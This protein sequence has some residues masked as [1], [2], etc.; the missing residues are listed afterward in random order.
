M[1]LSL[2]FFC[3]HVVVAQD[4]IPEL[5]WQ[6]CFGG[7]G[8]EFLSDFSQPTY[9]YG[10]TKTLIADTDGGFV[11]GG[12]TGPNSNFV[13]PLYG[14]IDIVIFK[15]DREK[16]IVWK[17][18]IGGSK[19]DILFSVQADHDGGY[20][21][22]TTTESTDGDGTGNHS[23][24]SD[25]LIVKLDRNGKVVWKKCFGGT[26]HEVG[27]Q[28]AVVDDGYVFSASTFSYNGDII[29]RNDEGMRSDVWLVKL[30]F[31]GNIIW[32]KTIGGS[33]DDYEGTIK[34]TSDGGFITLNYTTSTDGDAVV[35]P[36]STAK[37]IDLW[38]VKLDANGQIQW[39]NRWN[40]GGNFDFPQDIEETPD[41]E[42]I[43]VAQAD[44]NA[45]NSQSG[46]GVI[47]KMDRNG[48]YKWHK[49]HA[50]A[51]YSSFTDVVI[52]PD[53]TYTVTGFTL[54]GP[55]TTNEYDV[56]LLNFDQ[57]GDLNWDKKFGGSNSDMGSSIVR[58][59][60]GTYYILGVTSSNNG[61]VTGNNGGSDFWLLQVGDYN[62]ITGHAFYDLNTNGI[63]DAN[64]VYIDDVRITAEKNSSINAAIPSNGLYSIYVDTGSF[65]VKATPFNDYFTVV[66][67]S[68]AAAFTSYGN[69]ATI[70]FALR[71]KP[72]R[73]DLVVYISL[74]TPARS[75][76]TAKYKIDYKN[77]GT[78]II[79]AGTVTM[80]S[81]RR[82][83]YLSSLP[84]HTSHLGDTTTWN[85]T[86][87]KPG[88]S[89][90]I[91]ASF[92]ISA[93][94]TTPGDILESI[95]TISPVVN[96]ETPANNS[97]WI[98]TFVTGSYDPNDKSESNAGIFTPTQ[99]SS[100]AYL[101]YLIR[102]QNVG[103]DTAFNIVVRDTLDAK[104]DWN[105]LQMISASHNYSLQSKD[106]NKLTWTFENILL[107]DSN[108]NEAGSHGY[109]IYTIKPKS[110]VVTGDI[111]RNSAS[112]YF[113]YNLP[114]RT[115]ITATEIKPA[116]PRDPLITGL[117][118]G[119]CGA[120]G[121]QKVKIINLPAGGSNTIVVVKIDGVATAVAADSTFSFN[122][123]TLTEGT[124][125]ISVEFTNSTATRTKT[126]GFNITQAAN[127]DVDVSANIT[128]ITSLATNIIV[129][130]ANT[131]G[132]GTA[133]LYTFAYDKNFSNIAQPESVNNTW[134][135]SPSILSI[136]INKIYV[137]MKTSATCF[138]VNT[139]IDSIV[140]V[141][142]AVTGITDPDMPGQ[143]INI[144]PNPFKDKIT[145]DGLSTS[146]T[147]SVRLYN[148]EGKQLLVKRI[149]GRSS[150]VVSRQHQSTGIYWLSIY[151]EKRHKLLGTV[152][153]LKE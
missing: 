61:D 110:T 119:Y 83:S 32:Q 30:N 142:I 96:D 7:T 77:V 63:K 101:T 79:T 137:R 88:Q 128:N 87:L 113:D 125:H 81:D 116:R 38:F 40:N 85:F 98:S 26:E 48:N 148:L 17:T 43:A 147:Y 121:V 33:F 58:T 62:T 135:F 10:Y 69:T 64:E 76:F 145:I 71:P 140:L 106:G 66:P 39:Q 50:N 146:K 100:G 99:V 149:S 5:T 107:P 74:L 28:V 3:A 55:G 95:V 112:I 12:Q 102:F 93:A 118:A 23:G 126:S 21:L 117:Q 20:I 123:G 31:S 84:A 151:D 105:S 90:S 4:R 134:T 44:S 13:T 136:G 42:F 65:V 8:A 129:T 57:N 130:A 19:K 122:T 89:G 27:A 124:H 15:I 70:D 59:I 6:K 109:I 37:G 36:P 80:I 115:N 132:G 46:R 131:T 92:V 82:I 41:G 144:Y 103:N 91:E 22:G 68:G 53:N 9:A 11:I 78:E 51:G 45:S 29:G 114:V 139:A 141:R 152:K 108:V 60:D 34:K 52:A 153:L 73:R 2:L 97:A 67:V 75:G 143:V 14:D 94:Q 127:P 16:N 56:W 86:D 138:V 35:I 24:L 72:G 49:H 18:S 111:I 120:P 1:L 25:V 54:N 104:L 133:P 47:I 150:L